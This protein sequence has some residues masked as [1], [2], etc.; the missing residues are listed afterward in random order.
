LVL[1]VMIPDGKAAVSTEVDTPY[2]LFV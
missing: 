2:S 1:E